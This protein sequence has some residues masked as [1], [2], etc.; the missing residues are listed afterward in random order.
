MMMLEICNYVLITL[1]LGWV[2][3]FRM[4]SFNLHRLWVV[5]SIMFFECGIFFGSSVYRGFQR[6]KSN[7]IVGE[8]WEEKG[9][10][11]N[12]QDARIG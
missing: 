1:G 10:E 4:L 7:D 9:R 12:L 11:W 2:V 3:I 5:A 8:I 6:E